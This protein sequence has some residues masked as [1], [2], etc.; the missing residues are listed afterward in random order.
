MES[1]AKSYSVSVGSLVERF[2]VS[3]DLELDFWQSTHPVEGIRAHQRIQRSRPQEYESEVPVAHEVLRDGTSIHV[4][5]RIDGVH[6]LPDHVIIEEI[7]TTRRDDSSFQSLENPRHWAQVKLYTYIYAVLHSPPLVETQLTYFHLPSGKTFEARRSF[8]MSQLEEFFNSLIDQFLN[9]E[10][11]IQDWSRLR[12]ET[13]ASL[14]FPFPSYRPGQRQMAVEVYRAIRD[15][16]HLLVQ[17]PTGIGKTLAAIFPALKAMGEASTKKILYLAARTTGKSVAQKALEQLRVEGLRLRSIVLTA[18]DKICFNP[19]KGC[20]A[21]ECAYA[22][23]YYDRV[24]K[25]I[26]ELLKL[27]LLKRESIEDAAQKHTVCPFELSLNL[28]TATDCIIC[29]YNYAFDPRA[30][31]RQLLYEQEF[32]PTLIVDEAHNLVDRARDMFS[33]ELSK[34]EV[35]SVRRAVKKRLPAIARQLGKI[36]SWMLQQRKLLPDEN[37]SAASSE[38]PESLYPALRRFQQTVEPWISQKENARFPFRD[39]LL[40]FSFKVHRFLRV[41]DGYDSCYS[42]IHERN[43][44]EFRTKLFCMDPSNQ[45]ATALARTSSTIFFSGTLTPADYFKRLFG[46]NDSARSAI[47][48]SPFPQ[49]NLCVLIGDKVATTFRKRTETKHEVAEALSALVGP[50]KGNYLLFFPSYKYLNMVLDVF[51]STSPEVVTLVQTPEMRESEREVFLEQFQAQREDTVVG[52]AVMGGAFGEAIDLTGER[53]AGAAVVGVGLPA[54]CAE[55]ELIRS[56]FDEREGKGFDYAYSYPGII[57]VLQAAGRVIRSETDR[58]VVFLIDERFARPPYRYLL[59]SEWLP[60]PVRNSL[61]VEDLL[62]AFWNSQA[63]S[64]KGKE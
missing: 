60:A 64:S 21:E 45:L 57:R 54:I 53:L 17:A 31:L 30:I 35:L 58:G 3:G 14:D 6:R 15:Q 59:P 28:T 4:Q 2:C 47:L 7:K 11:A 43:G 48:P 42:T 62:T 46:C 33:A 51:H 36:N 38:A 49:S 18:K 1:S 16:E 40:D 5:G 23:G 19:E 12:N 22:R 13:I 9:Q 37:D 10:R 44:T 32:R 55:R 52:F 26:E 24:G 50:R 29:D 41:A 8:E 25:A 27:E 56:Y 39:Q 20:N 63:C 34:L 61:Q